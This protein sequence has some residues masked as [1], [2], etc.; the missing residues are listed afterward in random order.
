MKK[1]VVIIIPTYNEA[2]IIEETVH[3][4]FDIIQTIHEYDIDV[5]IF[6]SASQDA[7]QKIILDLQNYYPRLY[8]QTEKQKS[9]L[10]SAYNASMRYAMDH[11]AADIVIE[12]DA[13]LSHQPKYLAPMLEYMEHSDVVIGSRYI[14][15]G[16]IPNNWG[17]HRKLLSKLGSTIAQLLLTNKYKDFTSGFRATRT[18][19]LQKT[20]PNRFI[21]P[22]FA[23]K[24]ELFW[25]L[26]LGGAHI[27]EFPI[28][29]IDRSHGKSKMKAKDIMD[30]LRVLLQLRFSK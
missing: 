28:E 15:G 30:S 21:S 6:D 14:P 8:L 9:G 10:G 3:Q 25:L 27:I 20:L 22:N 13:D 24:L 7:T 26:H 19:I 18:S 5:L 29:F 2:L 16:S 1:K 17:W 12:F 4:L 11:L 23:Y